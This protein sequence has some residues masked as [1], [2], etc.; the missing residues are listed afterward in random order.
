MCE[1]QVKL[2]DPL[3]THSPYLSALAMVLPHNKALYK[4]PGYRLQIAVS[5]TG[6]DGREL[7]ALLRTP[8]SLNP[9]SLRASRTFYFVLTYLSSTISPWAVELSWQQV[10]SMTTYKPRKQG[11]V[12]D[13]SSSARF[14]HARLQVSACSSYDLCYPG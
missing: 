2:C 6:G 5:I 4:S 10:F 8:L 11:S 9:R 3:L 7:A 1:W 12:C 13:Q 14:V